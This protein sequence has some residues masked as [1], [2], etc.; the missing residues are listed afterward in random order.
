[1]YENIFLSQKNTKEF[2]RSVKEA[3]TV[4]SVFKGLNDNYLTWDLQ[5]QYIEK[6]VDDVNAVIIQ[7]YF[8]VITSTHPH[9]YTTITTYISL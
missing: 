9:T 2:L 8:S 7:G 4:F 3:L 5:S 1:M 6:I